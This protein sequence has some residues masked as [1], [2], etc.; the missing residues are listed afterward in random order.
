MARL[1]PPGDVGALIPNGG[2]VYC[3]GMGLAGFAEEAALAIRESFLT[4]GH[5][6]GLTLYH[7]T[8][9]GNGRDRGVHH[10]ALEG[11]LKRIVGGHFGVGGPEL[12]RLIMANKIEAY[13]LPQGALVLMPRQ[14]AG[15]RPGFITKVGLGTFVDPRIEGGKVNAAAQ[16]D[17]VELLELDGEEWLRYRTPKV[18]VA[19]LRG[20]VADEKGNVTMAREGVLLEALS[21]AQAA[22]ASGGIVIVQVEHIVK[23][24][25]LHPKDVKIPG[26]LVDYLVVGRPEY[27]L[28][29]MGTYFN[30]V[31][32]GDIKV[33]TRSLA[34]L[35]LD[36]RKLIARRAALELKPGAV[37]NLGIGMPEG[38][39]AIA[40]EEKIEHLLA[41]TLETGPIGGVPASGL[42]FGHA[43]NAE[44]VVEQPY[45][46]DFYDGGGIDVAFLGLAQSD[47]DGNVNVS[48]FSGRPVGC[49]G[50][51]N[52]TQNARKVVFCGTFTAGGLE[53]AVEDGRLRIVREG[54]NRKFLEQV[55]QI[56]FSGRYAAGV[57]QS[58]LYVTE[59]AVFRLTAE[60][61]ELQEIAP[62]I[63]IERD[64]LPHMAFPP[65]IRDVRTMEA[66]LFQPHWGQLAAEL[67]AA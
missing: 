57:G 59:R 25:T 7:S 45:Q 10:F 3:T 31:Y 50:F 61:L 8:G 22:R 33:P 17:L 43:A 12:M 29:T 1:I 24:G 30:P 56:T 2:T 39:A 49:G 6:R 21:I 62:G 32:A 52:I 23:S 66:G 42:D 4:T 34:P 58:V 20:S 47:R 53:I 37:V 54:R 16:D 67:G 48:K 63:D 55:E 65:L 15:R 18:D 5:P 14:I 64:I 38:V 27:H 46:F 51:I 40:A 28:Q 13:N 60:G 35:P 44:A 26:I 11:L 9:V 41:L 36:E 19:L